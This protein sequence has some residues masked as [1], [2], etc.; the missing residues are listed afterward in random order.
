MSSTRIW[1]GLV[2]LAIISFVGDSLCRSAASGTNQE[3]KLRLATAAVT[4]LPESFGRWRTV[5]SQPLPDR[6]LQMLQCSTH[7]SRVYVDEET[8]DKASLILL[9]GAAGPLVSHTPEVCY[10][11]AA[12]DVVQTAK[13]EEVRGTGDNADAFD[14]VVF[15]SR[16]LGGE[17]QEV[18]YAW[19]SPNGHWEAPRNPRL[20]LAGSPLLYKIQL[21]TTYD[22]KENDASEGSSA[23]TAGRRFL[24]DLL[25]A[26]DSLLQNR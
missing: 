12:F 5:E 22:S 2:V 14:R 25:P 1:M 20:A 6:V 17:I 21:S 9:V 3:E 10:S 18:Y 19:R 23:T 26:L 7:Q 24:A 16:G 4:Q 11:S 13:P 15:R 8:G